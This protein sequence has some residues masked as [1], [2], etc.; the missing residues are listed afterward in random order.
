[1]F[2]TPR[3]PTVLLAV[4]FGLGHTAGPS[5]G[6]SGV[7][8]DF[9]S[10]FSASEG[11]FFKAKGNLVGYFGAPLSLTALPSTIIRVQVPH[12]LTENLLWKV[13][14]QSGHWASL[15]TTPVLTRG[16]CVSGPLR[17]ASRNSFAKILLP[18]FPVLLPRERYLPTTASR[19][20]S[21]QTKNG[22]ASALHVNLSF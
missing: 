2:P 18:F 9:L 3:H 20:G 14:R 7:Q 8:V 16:F 17:S 11:Q 12:A 1:M 19:I 15:L 21:T 10:F 22:F 4:P 13:Q 5:R 6:P